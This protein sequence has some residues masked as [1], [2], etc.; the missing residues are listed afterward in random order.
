[1]RLQVAETAPWDIRFDPI[2][3]GPTAM[4][5][6]AFVKDLPSFTEGP[7]IHPLESSLDGIEFL[8]LVA[9]RRDGR[10]LLGCPM[11]FPGDDDRPTVDGIGLT[12]A[13]LAD[14]LPALRGLPIERTWAG[15]LPQSPD[16]LPIL[17]PVRSLDGLFVAAGH[18]F[19]VLAGPLSG[20]LLAQVIT[21]E[22]PDLDLRPF[23]YERESIAA[24]VAEHRRW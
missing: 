10:L 7:F 2:L 6:Y 14:H 5:Q 18:V 12:C 16:A 20:K 3:Y 1:M 8:E 11:D 15:L 13:I 22:T 17:G 19:G 21:G 9:Q 24:A 23:A 4:K